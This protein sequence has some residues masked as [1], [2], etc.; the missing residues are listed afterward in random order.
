VVH[1]ESVEE[2]FIGSNKF[3]GHIIF[4]A[5]ESNIIKARPRQE[6]QRKIACAAGGIDTVAGGDPCTQ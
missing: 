3:V 1:T 2:K 4:A 5:C 6:G